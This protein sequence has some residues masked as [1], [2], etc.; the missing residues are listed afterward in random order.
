MVCV[1][2]IL[3]LTLRL[4]RVSM[5]AK[6]LGVAPLLPIYPMP[7]ESRSFLVSD[8]FIRRALMLSELLKLVMG[9]E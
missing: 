9:A 6:R 2:P 3:A 8:M 5:N 1:Q 7:P 4:V